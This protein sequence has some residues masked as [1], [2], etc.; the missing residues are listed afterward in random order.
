MKNKNKKF[1]NKKVN[2]II[3][4]NNPSTD[5]VDK[6]HKDKRMRV[7]EYQISYTEL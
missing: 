1:R 7:F 4:L 5:M 3:C 2:G 6:I